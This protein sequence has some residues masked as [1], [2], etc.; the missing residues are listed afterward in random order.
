M[1]IITTII[2]KRNIIIIII[3]VDGRPVNA[4]AQA[5]PEPPMDPATA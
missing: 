3:I 5:P 4:T 1:I 2:I